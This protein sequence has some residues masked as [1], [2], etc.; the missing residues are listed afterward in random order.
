M[1]VAVGPAVVAILLAAWLGVAGSVPAAERCAEFQVS[2]PL[3][4]SGRGA[5]VAPAPDGGFLVVWHGLDAAD[6]PSV[7]ARRFDAN[8]DPIGTQQRIDTLAEPAFGA[9]VARNAAGRF[10][11]AWEGASE[12]DDVD[13]GSIQARLLAPTGVPIAAPFQVNTYTT[14][15]QSDP[16]VSSDGADGFVVAWQSAGSGGTDGDGT[17][18]QARRIDGDGVP[19]GDQFQVNVVTT[20]FQNRP[21]VTGSA[22]GGFV[23]SWGEGGYDAQSQYRSAVRFR[24][25]TSDGTPQGDDLLVGESTSQAPQYQAIGADGTGGFVVVWTGETGL[26]AVRHDAA[27]VP[28]GEPI[29]VAT[30]AI[31]YQ[32]AVGVAGDGAGGF[33][34]VWEA[35]G[36]AG[37][38]PGEAWD[39]HGRVFDAAG[40]G[41]PEFLVNVETSGFQYGHSVARD[42]DGFVVVWTRDGESPGPIH[43][44]RLDA[45]GCVTTTTTSTTTTTLPTTLVESKRLVLREAHGRHPAKAIFASRDAGIEPGDDPTGMGG[46]LR[47]VSLAGRFD[48]EVPLPAAGWRQGRHA[49]RYRGPEGRVRVKPG[50]R[51][52][53]KLTGFD[54]ALDATDPTPIL[55]V[56]DVGGRRLC[57]ELPAASFDTRHRKLVARSAD[58]PTV[59]DEP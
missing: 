4:G 10:L 57:A 38:V 32:R 37:G 56:L 35:M 44:R 55:V 49:L 12:G 17:S 40:Q 43:G 23:V 54:L 52:D 33:M 31:C 1:R 13:G 48:V 3:L 26:E 2:D 15:D 20:D 39:L 6:A 50:K 5:V 30:C 34:V 25:F 8:G 59:C 14:G 7:Q 21:Q 36:D 41:E 16:A 18:I 19:V 53:A 58:A 47:I 29:T 51:I 45:N 22:G 42:G 9:A 24:R 28:V 27:G 11:V 46:R